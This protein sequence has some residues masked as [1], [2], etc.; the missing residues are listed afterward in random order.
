M[1]AGT[2]CVALAVL[3]SAG[4]AAPPGQADFDGIF[5]RWSSASAPG[6]AVG[7][8]DRGRA[9]F[10]AYG[11]A[12]LEHDAA[13][14]PATIFE[15]GSVSKQFTAAAILL[16]AQDGRLRLDDDIRKYLP[17]MPDYGAVI[18]IDHLLTHSSGLRDW[19]FLTEIEG[20]PRT[21]RAM[22]QSD[23]LDMI[24]RQKRLNHRP[25]AEY[26]YTNSGYSLLAIIV[27]R[28]S[29]RSFAD[30][31]RDAIFD[32]LG[33]K[34]TRWR[35]DFRQI[36]KGRAIAYAQSPT[37]YV[38]RMPFEDAIGAGGLLTTVGDLLI[39]NRALT[40][41]GLGSFVAAEF[42]RRGT[43]NDGRRIRYARGLRIENRGGMPE[44]S[45]AGA[46]GAY[47]AW[48]GRFP[49]AGLSI[50]ILCNA[51]DVGGSAVGLGY[52]VADRFLPAGKAPV[53]KPVPVDLSRYRGLF[54]HQGTRLP[55]AFAMDGTA[56]LA[57]NRAVLRPI[58]PDR[59]LMG[60][61]L[62]IF[63]GPDRLRVEDADGNIAFYGRVSAVAS[64]EA[65]PYLG[66]YAS[67]EL[68][69][70]YSVERRDGGIAL[71]LERRP[72][73]MVPLRPAYRDTFLYDTR[74]GPNT[75]IV[76]FIRD[77]AGKIAAMDVGWNDRV[78]DVRF[79]RTGP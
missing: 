17:E 39:W 9:V 15:A 66:R 26:S 76:R 22:T 30:F 12:D 46:T 33:M 41:H 79:D 27:E 55:L 77:A 48:L 32:R 2:V 29:G 72:D 36:V 70:A 63:D 50:A 57:G 6:C 35:S 11:M 8:E 43:L 16:L 69:A 23:I 31:S 37:G 3:A 34:S 44:I 21:T 51:G 58:G 40:A 54:A 65:Q 19:G 28:V 71:R 18:T 53:A 38:Q 10:R 20:W 62:L 73:I 49:D 14:T 78:R 52:A 56:L 64:V 45:H 75:A 5:A 13:N 24:A 4:R 25:G 61:D 47:R 74:F 67:A 7:V 59:F 1:H 42:E 60:D 68:G